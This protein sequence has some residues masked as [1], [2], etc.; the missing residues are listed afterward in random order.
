MTNK[1][2]TPESPKRP[3][4]VRDLAKL[5]GVPVDTV[6]RYIEQK[7]LPST[8]ETMKADPVLRV[9]LIRGLAGVGFSNEEI[10]AVLRLEDDTDTDGAAVRRNAAAQAKQVEQR[11][12]LLRALQ[13]ELEHVIH[14][15][16]QVSRKQRDGLLARLMRR[17]AI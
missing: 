13:E 1:T 8:F 5:A 10:S 7:L 14:A 17:G 4:S 6:R 11:L 16:F 12:A 3:S 9:R 2:P 15:S